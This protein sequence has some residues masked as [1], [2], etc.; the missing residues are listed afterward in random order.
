MIRPI[1]DKMNK[2]TMP[3][4]EKKNFFLECGATALINDITY[5][6]QHGDGFC[7]R[8]KCAATATLCH[9]QAHDETQ[10]NKSEYSVRLQPFGIVIV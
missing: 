3:I 7:A 10:N 4:C 1:T 6:V 9:S 5:H 8:L 2:I